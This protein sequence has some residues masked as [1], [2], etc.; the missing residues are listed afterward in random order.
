[1]IGPLLIAASVYFVASQR[2]KHRAVLELADG[3]AYPVNL[4]ALDLE[5]ETAMARGIDNPAA[6]AYAAL[7]ALYPETWEGVA[8]SWPVP[9]G[10]PAN[11]RALQ[12]RAVTRAR[13]LMAAI[14]ESAA[15][16]I[17]R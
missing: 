14:E 9:A 15:E 13:Y 3:P 11:L 5:I 6:A 8:V 1:M 10:A 12:L 16:D 4:G 2:R 17:Y 7:R